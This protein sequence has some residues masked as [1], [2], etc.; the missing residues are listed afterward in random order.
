LLSLSL[1]RVAAEEKEED[2]EIDNVRCLEDALLIFFEEERE[3]REE[4]EDPKPTP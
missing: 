1:E 3:E 4:R 2:E